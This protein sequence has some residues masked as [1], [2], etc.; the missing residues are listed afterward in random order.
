LIIPTLNDSEWELKQIAEF[1]KNELG[2]ETPWHI[3]RFHPMYKLPDLPPT[4]ISTLRKARRIGLD[5]GLKYVYEGNVPGEDGEN[6]Y[7]SKCKNPIIQR[8]GYQIQENK[9]K[10]SKCSICGKKIDGVYD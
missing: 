10:N 5:A 1:I 2:G 7:C 6:T 3:T 9:I 8:Y 4:P